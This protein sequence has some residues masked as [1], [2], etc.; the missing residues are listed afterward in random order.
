MLFVI[1]VC[2]IF[3][4]ELY[5]DNTPTYPFRGAGCYLILGKVVEDFGFPG[6]EVSKF[7]KLQ[8]VIIL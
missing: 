7:A 3:V 5:L 2:C 8:I 4:P 1:A 6:I